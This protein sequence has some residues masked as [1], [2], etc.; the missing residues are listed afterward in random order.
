M[1][2]YV[3]LKFPLPLAADYHTGALQVRSKNRMKSVNWIDVI[4]NTSVE[5]VKFVSK[6]K[7]NELN[8]KSSTILCFI[9]LTK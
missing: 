1:A 3:F 5:K 4:E 8:T 2:H 7:W 6:S 9:F